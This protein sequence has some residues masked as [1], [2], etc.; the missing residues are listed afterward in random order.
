[1]NVTR[2]KDGARLTCPVCARTPDLVRVDVLG[3]PHGFY[4]YEC[5][6]GCRATTPCESSGQ[7]YRQWEHR[8]EH[9]GEL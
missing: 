6:N 2:F 1:M 4:L 7:A 3:E 5:P 8:F 9:E